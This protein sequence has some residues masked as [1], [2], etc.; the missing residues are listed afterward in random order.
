FKSIKE[1]DLELSSINVL[2]GS[3]G[4]GKSNFV[5][6][7]EMLQKILMRELSL[8]TGKK[9]ITPLLYNGKET[10]DSILAKFY[11]S[12]DLYS[13]ELEWTENESLL[14]RN[15]SINFSGKELFGESGHR[16]SNALN[17]FRE[18][19]SHMKTPQI[20]L[21]PGWRI[22]QFHDTSPSSRIKS[23]HNISNSATLLH[24][25]RNLA[26]YLY[27]LK[28]HFPK[29]YADILY[30]IRLVIPYFNDFVLEPRELNE[31][32][33][34]LHWH[35]TDC[36]DVF[37]AAQLSDGSLRF[38]CL[39]ALLL[40]PTKL[41]PSTIII[42]EP[43][44]GLHPFAITI[45]AEMVQ[46]AAVNKQIILATQS[47]ELLDNFDVDD[48]IIVDNGENGS[49]FKRLDAE[50][51]NLWLEKDYTLGELWNKNILGGRP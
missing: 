51:L 35:K 46:K 15:E 29:E 1:C 27:R 47:A 10:T 39:T 49:E 41:Q 16:E 19:S 3:N 30:A 36:D 13:F 25:A 43:E 33:I 34:I 4:A 32:Q 7:F 5:S 50:K 6:I 22:Y 48:V 28:Q 24:D 40:Q 14:F 2:I 18:I 23:E 37:N 26:A 9:G 38:I 20:M 12:S 31:E 8:Y 42:D 17:R 45:L 11:F 21:K 44:L